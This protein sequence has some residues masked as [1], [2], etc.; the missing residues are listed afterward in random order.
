MLHTDVHDVSTCAHERE[1][2]FQLACVCCI[3]MLTCACVDCRYRCQLQHSD[4][5]A[6]QRGTRRCAG[7][8]NTLMTAL[9][10]PNKHKIRYHSHSC[11]RYAIARVVICKQSKGKNGGEGKA[12]LGRPCMLMYDV[13]H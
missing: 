9:S 1:L 4:C 10:K 13:L 8:P 2:M 7:S 6:L 5:A 12:R 11:M 3:Q